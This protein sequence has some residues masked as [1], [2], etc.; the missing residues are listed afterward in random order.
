[1]VGHHH[2]GQRVRQPLILGEPELPDHQAA[3]MEIAED[4]CAFVGVGGDQVDVVGFA[5][6]PDA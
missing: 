1:M 2:P 6:P 3:E 4:W 5:E